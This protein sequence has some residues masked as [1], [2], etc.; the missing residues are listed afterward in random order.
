[1]ADNR[2]EDF[3]Q[4]PLADR[5]DAAPARGAFLNFDRITG[6]QPVSDR[7]GSIA[8]GAVPEALAPVLFPSGPAQT[9]ALLDGARIPG[10][11]EVL[12]TS[13]LGHVCLFRGGSFE[14][15]KQVAPWLVRIEDSGK[16]T[17]NLFRASSR[18][19]HLWGKEAGIFLHTPAPLEELAAHLR[20][21]TK[22]RDKTG[23]WVFF[24]FWDPLVAQVY[25]GGM[26]DHA[27]RI[28]Q[29]FRLPSGQPMAMIVQTGPQQAVRM[30]P[31]DQLPRDLPRR[32]ISFDPPDLALLTE[33]SFHALARQL[34]EWLVLDYP[35]PFA[36]RTPAQMRAIG[37]HVVA[38]GRWLGL[39]MKQDFAFLAQMMMTSGGWFLQDGTLPAMNRLIEETAAP[40]AEAMAAAYAD[41][42]AQTPQA[43][44]LDRWDALRAALPEDAAQTPAGL[45]RIIRRLLPDTAIDAATASTRARLRELGVVDDMTLARAVL[46]AL[47]FG[48]RFFEDPFKPWTELGAEAA[49][50]AAWRVVIE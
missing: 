22:A 34:A 33:V 12:E 50:A 26:A 27:E 14:R 44:L 21:F 1:M 3:W 4:L 18:A 49:I 9:Y 36:D 17:R 32:A 39:T 15:M 47:L 23:K 19:W 41:L 24:R 8:A 45:A 25:F 29:I 48:P 42:Q 43:G 7:P 6:I 38:T 46:L 16:F 31:S 30:A 11:P 20:R 10:L 13:R 35:A 28:G 2:F 37:A 5:A 40:K